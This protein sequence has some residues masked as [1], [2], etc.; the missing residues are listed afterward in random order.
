MESVGLSL[1]SGPQGGSVR[2]PHLHSRRKTKILTAL[3]HK[4]RFVLGK[5][6]MIDRVSEL[7]HHALIGHLE[8]CS[9][10]KD[11]WVGWATLNWKLILNYV[12]T[13]SLLSNQWS[14][15]VFIEDDDA[16]RIL[17]SL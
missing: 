17:N 3:D 15:I 10:N 11:E 2:P 4:C 13:I 8:Y 14:I 9:L 16:T 5:D 12:P 7:C 1:P 6:V